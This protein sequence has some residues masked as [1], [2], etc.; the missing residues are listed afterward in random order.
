MTDKLLSILINPVYIV[1]IMLSSFTVSQVAHVAI[2]GDMF[3]TG[4]GVSE[5]AL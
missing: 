2:T 3:Y 5:R 4:D 1:V